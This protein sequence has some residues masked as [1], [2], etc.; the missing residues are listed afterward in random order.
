MKNILAEN[1]LRFGVKNLDNMQKEKIQ[2]L[3][4]QTR[5]NGTI[6]GKPGPSTT[7]ANLTAVAQNYNPPNVSGYIRITDGNPW[8]AQQRANALNTF[9]TTNLFKSTEIQFNKEESTVSE[10]QVLGP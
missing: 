8:L 10:V 3:N 6:Y 9:L 2:S 4:E 5:V 7:L 1:I